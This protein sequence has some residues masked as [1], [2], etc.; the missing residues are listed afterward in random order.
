MIYINLYDFI[1]SL[2]L[3]LEKNIKSYNNSFIDNFID[4]LKNF[5]SEQDNLSKLSEIS[6][7]TLFTLDR[8]E[9]KYAVCENKETGEMFDIPR[10]KISP[11]AKDGDLL[12]LTNGIYQIVDSQQKKF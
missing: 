8:Y 2:D 1:N 9:G 4:E 7:D 12:K 11:Y 3:G 5:L 10:S 6:P